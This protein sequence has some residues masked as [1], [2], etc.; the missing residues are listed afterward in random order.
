MWLRG[1]KL[2]VLGLLGFCASLGSAAWAQQVEKPPTANSPKIHYAVEDLILGDK[3]DPDSLTSRTYHCSPSEQFV[4]FT[5]CTNRA[6]KGR[7]YTVYSILHSPDDKIVY[8]NKT[9]EPA[10]SSPAEA[11]EEL[12]RIAQKLG[13]QPRIIEM[14]S[15]RGLSDGLIA[16]WGDVVLTPV[17]ADNIKKLADGR[18]PKLGFMVDFVADFERSA[19]K[20]LPVYKIGGG[21]GLVLAVSYGKP[22]HGTLRFIAVDASKFASP[23]TDQ[24]PVAA[25]SAATED[26]AAIAAQRSPTPDR[27]ATVAQ[28]SLQPTSIPNE[29]Q[30]NIADLKHTISLLKGDLANATKKITKLETQN[31]ETERQLKQEAQARSTVEAAKRQIEQTLLETHR[32]AESHN[33]VW[34]IFVSMAIGGLL[35][36]LAIRSPVFWN[37]WNKSKVQS[38]LSSLTQW[39]RRFQQ[40]TSARRVPEELF[41]RELD[42]HVTEINLTMQPV[43]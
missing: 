13:A 37:H 20:G 7:A 22:D 35:A 19:K 24:A 14:P 11:K 26:Q 17:D 21:P 41:G 43:S 16:V 3:V 8:A 15:R 33:S 5:W 36:L 38:K 32:A 10:F 23:A 25:Q 18:S 29:S 31:V 12:Q 30:T 39:A 42:K 28:P 9:L 34:T 40:K 6:S 4:G 2:I 1:A 27:T